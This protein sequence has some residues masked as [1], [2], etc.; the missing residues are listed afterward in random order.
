MSKIAATPPTTASLTQSIAREENRIAANFTKGL[1][2]EGEAAEAKRALEGVK[3]EL[4]S[5]QGMDQK[6]T[7]DGAKDLGSVAQMLGAQRRNVTTLSQDAQ[8]D[9]TK[10]I[11]N[12]EGRIAAGAE[13]GTLTKAQVEELS[14]T[15][16]YYKGAF[17]QT[18]MTP[19]QIKNYNEGL[20]GLSADVRTKSRDDQNNVALRATDFQER[21]AAGVTDGSLSPGEAR[22]L[23]RQLMNDTFGDGR[24]DGLKLNSM[25][26]AIKDARNN[27]TVNVNKTTANLWSAVDAACA[28]GKMTV[29]EADV[30]KA[31]LLAI[32]QGGDNAETKAVELNLVRAELRAVNAGVPRPDTLTLPNAGPG[33]TGPFIPDLTLP[34][35]GPGNTGPY[36]PDLNPPGAR[37]GKSGP[38]VPDLT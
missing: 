37:T 20:K 36:I 29:G 26:D 9:S 2:T 17:G 16:N 13:K 32:K 19:E 11:S 38:F 1:L 18:N 6:D 34:N 3:S 30:F 31:K 15:L 7:F 28:K 10:L 22:R 14:T 23:N 21:I 25:D 27:T 24:P 35:A 12:I 8:L 5:F 33:K 4:A